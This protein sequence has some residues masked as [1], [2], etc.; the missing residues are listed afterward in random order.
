[1]IYKNRPLYLLI[2]PASGLCNLRCR[3]CFYLDAHAHSRSVM[4]LEALEVI[5]RKACEA[6]GR[7]LTIAFQGGEPTLAGL[8]FFRRLMELQKQY[9]PPGLTV[10]NALQTNGRLINDEWAAFF[11]E[12]Q[13]LVGLSM[14]G[15]A[16]IHDYN[17]ID[18][19]SRG[20]HKDAMRAAR[21]LAQHGAE[22]NILTV[23]HAGTAA[24][25]GKVYGFF[26]RNNLPWMQF[27]P[28]ISKPDDPWN[29]TAEAYG[30]CLCRM[31]DVWYRDV[32]A[33][34]FVYIRHF[35]NLVGI[36][37]GYPPEQCS[38][39]GVCAPQ[40]VIE[41][42]GTVY[43]CDFY[44]RENLCIGNLLTDSFEEIEEKRA[45]LGFVEDSQQVSPACKSCEWGALCRGGCRRDRDPDGAGTQVLHNKYCKAYKRFFAYAYERLAE[46]AR[47]VP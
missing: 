18:L 31:F 29:M 34:K 6:A 2:K 10:N 26:Q 25:I 15:P 17:R 30:D 41:S 46:L 24:H 16:D 38:M 23:L 39:I 19:D 44:V 11:T 42:D 28:C 45:K 33:K 20:S 21:L 27:I 32:K 40:T 22:F 14:D 1:M 37:R 5:V 36:M 13:F 3:Y 8:P 12:H 47:G 35:E 43:P 9:A 7:H 4:S